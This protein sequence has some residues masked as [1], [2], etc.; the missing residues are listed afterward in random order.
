MPET[1]FQDTTE[2]DTIF[3]MEWKVK[4]LY[5]SFIFVF[6]FRFDA[7]IFELHNT[8]ENYNFKQGKYKTAE[9]ATVTI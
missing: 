3:W 8:K 1:I 4:K 7:A 5:W 9:E 6:V 2:V